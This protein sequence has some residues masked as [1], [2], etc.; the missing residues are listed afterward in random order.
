MYSKSAVIETENI[1]HNVTV[2]EFAI[3]RQDVIIGENVHIGAGSIIC[4]NVV[5]D[6]NSF[7]G[8][9][10][11]LGEPTLQFYKEPERHIFKKTIIGKNSLIR[12]KTIIYEDVIIGENFH[13]GHRVTIREGTRIGMHCRIGTLCDLQGKLNIGNHVNLHSNVHLGQLSNIEDFVWIYPYVVLTNDPYPPHGKLKGVTV[14]K[15]A[16]IAT[17]ATI[18]PGIE[19]GEN[20]LVGAGAVVRKNVPPE[21][22]I[23][24]NPGKDI[25][26]VRDLKDEEGNCLYP[27]K[28]FLKNYRG[29]PWQE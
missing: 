8:P 18:M 24:G 15:F 25:C 7:I 4:P 22:V 17:H 13:S 2:G 6:S 12:S 29:Y 23:V 14:R 10:S 3:I 5:I 19:I 20:A 11:I 9:Y 28:D 21:R 1:G 16:Q 27:W 26:S